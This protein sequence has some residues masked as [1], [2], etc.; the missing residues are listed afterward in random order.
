MLYHSS[1]CQEEPCAALPTLPPATDRVPG[2]KGMSV[3]KV[4]G[5]SDIGGSNIDESDMDESDMDGSDMDNSNI[6]GSDMGG[7][8]MDGSDNLFFRQIL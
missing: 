6:G 7:S 3:A 4:F 2:K 8:D 1:D 5:L